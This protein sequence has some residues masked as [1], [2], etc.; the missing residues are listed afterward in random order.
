MEKVDIPNNEVHTNSG[1]KSG[2]SHERDN[3]DQA[4]LSSANVDINSS[5]QP[6]EHNPP[7]KPARSC[8]ITGIKVGEIPRRVETSSPMNLRSDGTK[9]VVMPKMAIVPPAS[10][11][12][13]RMRQ[14]EACPISPAQRLPCASQSTRWKAKTPFETTATVPRE[15]QA[16][17]RASLLHARCRDSPD[18]DRSGKPEIRSCPRTTAPTMPRPHAPSWGKL[19]SRDSRHRSTTAIHHTPPCRET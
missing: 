13:Q 14:A 9:T 12:P 18:R 10:A 5:R 3:F 19:Q 2:T 16:E 6:V 1:A 15:K 8:E 7:T 11:N 4:R 17:E